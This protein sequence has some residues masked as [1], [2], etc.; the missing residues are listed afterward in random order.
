MGEAKRRKQNL[1]DSYG[2]TP[3]VLKDG[4]KTTRR[5]SRKICTGSLRQNG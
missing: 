5:T 3:A 2:K 1:G 4:S